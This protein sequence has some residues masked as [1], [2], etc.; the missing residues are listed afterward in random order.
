MG[1]CPPSP[2][3][4]AGWA[5]SFQEHFPYLAL[6]KSQE[7]VELLLKLDAVYDRTDDFQKC[8]KVVQNIWSQSSVPYCNS[9]KVGFCLFFVLKGVGRCDWKLKLEAMVL[10]AIDF[11]CCTNIR[12]TKFV[13]LLLVIL[14]QAR[15]GYGNLKR[16][17][18]ESLQRRN[19]SQ[20]E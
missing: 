14:V 4:R 7:R 17:T 9:D 18:T 19:T 11:K 8:A 15:Q 5:L 16:Q 3:W 6:W 20:R 12:L 13:I 10:L 1:L 2:C